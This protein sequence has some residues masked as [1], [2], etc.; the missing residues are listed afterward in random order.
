MEYK[1]I[2]VTFEG[3]IG[4]LTINRPKALNA[5][6]IETLQEIQMGIQEVKDHPEVKV[7]IVTGSGE[8]A[9]VAGADISQMKNMNSIEALN[10]SKLGHLTLRMIQDLD[11]PVIAAVNGFA[12][13]GGTEIALACD[14]IYASENARFGLPEVTLGVFP[15]FGGTQRLPRL[16][17]KGNA[18]E[19]I[20]TGKMISAQEAYQIGIV[21][22]VFPQAALLE[23][24]KKT[25]AQ[26][27]AN[28]AVGVRLAKMVADA[29]F[30]MDLNEACTL[31]SY[32]FAVGFATEDQKEGMTAFIEKRK[33]NFKGR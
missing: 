18:K 2:L 16:I 7:L 31:E 19:L 9:F 13:G 20:F 8:K 17:G 30:D 10:F 24:T 14:F 28:G 5:L 15:G 26:I 25:A 27:A 12:L 22:R 23:E 3:E 4:I 6:N 32:A 1:N 33:P 29:G 21:N 11:R